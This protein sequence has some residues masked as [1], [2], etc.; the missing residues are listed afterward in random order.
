MTSVKRKNTGPEIIVR[1]IL[2]RMGYRYRLH[3]KD[4]PGSPD[5]VFPARLKTIFVHGCFWHGHNCRLGKLPKSNIDYWKAKI[6]K[7]KERDLKKQKELQNLGWEIL[8]VWQCELRATEEL[9]SKLV[10]YLMDTDVL[11]KEEFQKWLLNKNI[12]KRVCS[13]YVSRCKRIQKALNIDLYNTLKSKDKIL[14]IFDEINS[15]TEEYTS[16]KKSANTLRVNL[17][18]AVRYYIEFLYG[19]IFKDSHRK[20]IDINK[21]K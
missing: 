3:R 15:F 7:N 8:I 17:C 2:H 5:I 1:R 14:N 10:H 16:N 21:I 19:D 4:L 11:K 20:I 13:D 12:S 18:V 9:M 6:E